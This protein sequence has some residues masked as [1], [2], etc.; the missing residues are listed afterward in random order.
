MPIN[1]FSI[2]L[3]HML[4]PLPQKNLNPY[5]TEQDAGAG[6]DWRQLQ[7]LFYPVLVQLVSS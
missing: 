3:P 6:H 2:S 1:L 5:L 7:T 4:I